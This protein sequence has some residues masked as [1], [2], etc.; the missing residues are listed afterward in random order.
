MA[1]YILQSLPSSCPE[2]FLVIIESSG[3]VD[4]YENPVFGPQW[5]SLGFQLINAFRTQ[6]IDLSPSIFR[7]VWVV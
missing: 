1:T 4:L 7:V 3:V 6:D 2:A 5:S